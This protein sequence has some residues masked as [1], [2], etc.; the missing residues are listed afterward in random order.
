M[1]YKSNRVLGLPLRLSVFSALLLTCLL[2][3]STVSTSYA[4]VR[5]KCLLSLTSKSS[6]TLENQIK[7]SLVVKNIGSRPCIST[8]LSMYYDNNESYNQSTPKPTSGTNY[9][10][11][12]GT[13]GAGKSVPLTVTTSINK[14]ISSIP[15]SNSVCLSATG[16][17]DACNDITTNI[18][19]STPTPLTPPIST[20]T[21]VVI[22][23]PTSSPLE[24]GVWVW[25]SPYAMG[26]V[27]SNDV[28]DKASVNGFNAIYIT[29]DDYLNIIDMPN[30]SLKTQTLN[31][32]TSALTSFITY[33]DQKGIKVDA[34]AGW[35]DWAKPELRYKAYNILEFVNS[36][37][38]SNPTSK[39]R[40]VQY[41]VEPYILPE[42]ETNKA[43]VLYDFVEMVNQLVIKNTSDLG[44]VMVIPHFYDSAQ[45]WTPQIMFNGNQAST[46]TH[47]LRILDTKQNNSITL[48]S[49]RDH[50]LGQDGTIALSQPEITEASLDQ[51]RVKINIAQ[52]TGN[53]DPN[54]VTFYGKTR[55]QLMAE[56]TTIKDTFSTSRAFGGLSIHYLDP[57]LQL[58][59]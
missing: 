54:Y 40:N 5:P 20:S 33:A 52:E 49:Y 32:Y 28:I 41:D 10:W 23:P 3:T 39:F 12:I 11:Y 8:Q 2:F 45:N 59:Q 29:I 46:F 35:R 16:A 34:E 26:T 44:I 56:L 38:A 15:I 58:P 7:Y 57:F 51:Y 9:Y 55:S 30:G 47:I 21:P 6:T 50:A 42:Y 14:I 37:N 27:R 25:E 31:S 48:M 43:A 19:N 22:A 36:Y 18:S 13:L 24:Y 4:A 17:N 53:V 1:K